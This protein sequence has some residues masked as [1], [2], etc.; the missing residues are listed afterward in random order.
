MPGRKYS[1]N[2]YKY[3]FNGK[4]IDEEIFEGAQDF[5][6]RIYDNRLGRFLSRDPHARKYP[7][8]SPYCFAA[9]NPILFVDVDGKGPGKP[10]G[11]FRAVEWHDWYS[12]GYVTTDYRKT[13]N[14]TD[15]IYGAVTGIPGAIAGLGE[16]IYKLVAQNDR[17]VENE[18]IIDGTIDLH[19]QMLDA[20][21]L[22]KFAGILGKIGTA[23]DIYK[24]VTEASSNATREEVLTEL[25]MIIAQTE[26]YATV[27]PSSSNTYLYI[28]RSQ[29][30]TA[31]DATNKL[32]QIYNALDQMFVAFDLSNKEDA[33]Q[34][35]NIINKSP[36]FSFTKAFNSTNA[37]TGSKQ[38][39]AGDQ[40]SCEG[41]GHDTRG[42]G[43][44]NNDRGA[45]NR[46]E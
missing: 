12:I 1:S 4:L 21:G 3:S 38:A 42:G 35:I 14:V 29:F 30:K 2:S 20:S 34:A 10:P 28:H 22:K 27:N 43:G 23:Y 33:A 36:A 24:I 19:E 5:G 18:V 40:N 16:N 32:N 31:Q 25:T 39:D 13:K 6:A 17:S 26:L 9:N 46:I 41:C 37:A 11:P 44:E 7:F 8:M 15:H 45:F